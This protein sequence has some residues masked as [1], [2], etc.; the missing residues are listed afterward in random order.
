M[1]VPCF[2]VLY[3]ELLFQS[4]YLRHFRALALNN[5]YLSDLIRF[6]G[7]G[8]LPIPYSFPMALHIYLLNH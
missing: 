7:Q 4:S 8:K 6:L 5:K 3:L 2:V 1:T